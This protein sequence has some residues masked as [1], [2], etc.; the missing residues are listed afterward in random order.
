MLNCYL[1]LF[2]CLFYLKTFFF[3][4]SNQFEILSGDVIVIILHFT[5]RLF[6]IESKFIDVLVLS[7]FNFVNFNLF[8]QLKIC[9]QF[10]KFL[11]IIL[12]QFYS[13]QIKGLLHVFQILTTFGC[14]W[15]NLALMAI[16]ISLEVF[17]QLP[18][19]FL[20]VSVASIM[21]LPFILHHSH[22]LHLFMLYILSMFIL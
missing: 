4:H 21:V 16:C 15:F 8:L 1:I 18:N 5:K 3:V 9:F 11:W 6:M 22:A 7:F 17:F 13:L 19:L 10:L 2:S 14:L 12:N 20:H